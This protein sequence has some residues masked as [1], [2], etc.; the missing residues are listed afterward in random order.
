M[1]NNNDLRNKFQTNSLK[2]IIDGDEFTVSVPAQTE[3]FVGDNVCLS[4]EF[5][6]ITEK[7][8]WYEQG[9]S[10]VN[11]E[12]FLDIGRT[13]VKLSECISRICEEEGV[14]INRESFLL[15]NYHKYVSEDKHSVILQRT[16]DLGPDDFGFD[17]NKFLAAAEKYFKQDLSWEGSG[18]YNPRI[19][20]RINMPESEHFNPAHKDVYQVF[21]KTDNI[22]EMVNIWIPVCGVNNGVGLPLSLGSHLICEDLVYRTKAGSTLNGKKYNVNCIKEWNSRHDLTTI[23]PSE[24]QM[25]VFSSFL[26]H[27]LARN[28]HRDTTRISL[29]FRLFGRN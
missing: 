4:K 14:A 5:G 20:A 10:I 21:D 25:I 18:E 26:I 19:I 27:G 2:Y 7:Q 13:K 28:L 11:L 24:N 22:P 9:F 6:D 23:C 12:P 1:K 29:E 15:E 8:S 17:I 16:R 3:F